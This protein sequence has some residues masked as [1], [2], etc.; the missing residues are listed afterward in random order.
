MTR[1]A[2]VVE[3]EQDTGIVLAELLKRWDYQPTVLR[4]GTTAI[5]WVRENKPDLIL[6]DL[7]L[8]DMDGFEICEALK[9]ERE[10]N[11]IPIIM[12]SALT[13]R[14]DKIKGLRVGA[15]QYLP[16]PF[17][18]SQ[19]E[20]AVKEVMSWQ[21]DVQQQGKHGEIRFE[22]QS[23][24][25]FLEELNNLLSALFLFSGLTETQSQQLSMAVREMGTNAI[26]WGHRKQI[27]RL[28]TVDYHIDAE[29][30]TIEI[31]DTGPGFNPT[32]IPHAAQSED[33]VSH[34]MVRET[35]GIREGGFGILMSR[36]LVDDLQFNEQGNQVR[37]IKYFPAINENASDEED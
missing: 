16:K 1:H 37:L 29:K 36:G 13:S 25:R 20:T 14:D 12:I 19:L 23:D 22:L 31:T 7:L 6:L 17:S 18:A 27:D 26:E 3:D 24:F 9:L 2:L 32:Q 11:L 8:P 30:V 35:L 21:E 5:S 33:P 34:M 28:V 4:E 15:N 10:T